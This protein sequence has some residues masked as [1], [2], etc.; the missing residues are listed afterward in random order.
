MKRAALACVLSITISAVAR[1]D[2]RPVPLGEAPLPPGSPPPPSSTTLTLSPQHFQLPY[3]MRDRWHRARVVYGVGA[4]V[5]LVGTGLTVASIVVMAVT[6]YPCNP[7]TTITDP[8]QHCYTNAIY[9][10]SNP[11]DAAPMLAYFGSSVSALGF[12]LQAA[13]LGWQHS[14]L[15]EMNWDTG[16]GLFGVGTAFG[17][18]GTA[19]VGM[20]YFFGLTNYLDSAKNPGHN[21]GIAILAT[22][23]TGVVLCTIGGL[24]YAIDAS[25]AKRAWLRLTTY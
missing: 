14:L 5:G 7:V 6:G 20:S 25:K 21:Q 10:P 11:T 17:V 9:H 3:G 19:A 16:R 8:N 12:I 24:L 22:S 18:V 2:D 13:G 23:I 15:R 4:G 1:A